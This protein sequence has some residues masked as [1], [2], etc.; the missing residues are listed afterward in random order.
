MAEISG[1]GAAFALVIF[2]VFAIGITA[3]LLFFIGLRKRPKSTLLAVLGGIIG[4]IIGSGSSNPYTI[5]LIG[6]V[7][8]FLIGIKIFKEKDYFKAFNSKAYWIILKIIGVIALIVLFSIFSTVFSGIASSGSS[9]AWPVLGVMIIALIIPT[10]LIAWIFFMKNSKHF[11]K[12][13][14][15]SKKN[16]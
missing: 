7:A 15:H 1:L 2:L 12:K 5:L 6:A 14:I 4:A 11:Q 10:A 3:F 9:G 8:G 16:K 13:K